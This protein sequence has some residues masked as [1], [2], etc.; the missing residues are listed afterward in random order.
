MMLLQ[1]YSM[2][3][4]YSYHHLQIIKRK[5]LLVQTATNKIN[6]SDNITTNAADS[7]IAN[8]INR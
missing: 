1:Q 5:T 2:I 6:M 8:S 7:I 4:D 3:N